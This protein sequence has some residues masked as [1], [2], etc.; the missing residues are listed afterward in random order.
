VT[1]NGISA[2]ID[3]SGRVME[4]TSGLETTVR[5]WPL[6]KNT[7]AR[8]FYT[9]HGDIFVYAC[10]LITLGLI[11]ATFTTRRTRTQISTKRR[12]QE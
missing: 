8:T 2:Y 4:E 5:T 6:T 12:G 9:V 10:A 3:P 11:S 1:N 7:E